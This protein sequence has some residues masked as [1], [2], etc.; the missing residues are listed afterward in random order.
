MIHR[1]AEQWKSVVTPQ[2]PSHAPNTSDNQTRDHGSP[3]S[4]RFHS[5]LG[6][7][8]RNDGNPNCV[9]DVDE[10]ARN[11]RNTLFF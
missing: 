8:P 11:H 4:T 3:P 5:T 7:S 1:R 6:T 9:E 2:R 10:T